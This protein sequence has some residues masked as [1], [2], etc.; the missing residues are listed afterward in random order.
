MTD[1]EHPLCEPETTTLQEH[2]AL[3]DR[4]WGKGNWIVCET[5]PL[6]AR[7]NPTRHHKDHHK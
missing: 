3:A 6:D 4:I 2:E 5:C 7:G 1:E